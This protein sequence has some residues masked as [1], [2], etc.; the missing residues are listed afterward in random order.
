MTAPRRNTGRIGRDSLSGFL[1]PFIM[2]FV[3]FLFSAIWIILMGKNPLQAY[4]AL[5][6]G[7][8]GSVSGIINTI[9]K[10]IP[11]A[12]CTFSVLISIKGNAFNIGAEGQLAMGAFGATLAGIY[13]K[14][15]PAPVHIGVCM[16]AS[17]VFGILFVLGPALLYALRGTNLL[18]ILLLMNN[19]ARFALQYFVLDL[20][21]SS[22]AL[23]PSTEEILGTAQLPYLIGP[24]Y[25]MT[26]AIIFV[27][28][29]AC[30]LQWFLSRTIAGYEMRAV[31][32]NSEAAYYSGIRTKKYMFFA[33]LL[34]GALAGIGGGLEILGNYHRLYTDFSPGFGYDGISIALLSNA[35]PI[36]GIFGSIAFG[37][38]RTGSLTMQA[39]VGISNE[40]ISVIQGSL[41]LCIAANY[42]VRYLLNRRRGKRGTI[43]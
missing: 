17:A 36:I 27:V 12:F 5:F 10:S 29:T 41:I 16:V 33:L 1:V 40:I 28:I 32:L 30:I 18:V 7:A 31:G 42:F 26:V 37:A 20:F 38:L 2:I 13:C 6:Q 9:K 15:L 25:R 39:R 34:S 22:N 24:P 4:A 35:N 14:G 21:K 23:V 19:I 3:S 11:I 8:F 43:Q